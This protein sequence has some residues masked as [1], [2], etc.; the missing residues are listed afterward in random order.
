MKPEAEAPACNWLC[1]GDVVFPAMLARIEGATR[2]VRLETYIF[3]GGRLADR[4]RATLVAASRRGVQVRVLLDG[5]GSYGLS[6]GYWDDLQAAGGS[7]RTFNPLSLHRLGIRNHRKLLV[8]DDRSA[9]IGGFNIAP[10]YEGDGVTCGWCDLGLELEGPLVAQLAGSFDEMFERADMK[11]KRFVTLRRSRGPGLS[12]RAAEA[13]S[14]RL[15]LSAPGR[16]SSPIKAALRADLQHAKHVQIV[17]AYFLPTRQIR[18]QLFHVA[19]HGGRVQLILAGKSDV[20][21]SQLAGRNL[22]RRFLRAGVEIYEYQPQILHAKLMVIDDA[23]YVGSANLDQRSLQIN[24]E[25]MV[26]FQGAEFSTRAREVFADTLAHC[27]R[28]TREEW[29]AGRSLWRS[30]KQR[31]AYWLLARIDPYIA[32]RQWRALPD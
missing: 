23:V 20:K 3:K 9:F 28:V 21:V 30:L 24:Y 1:S 32:A 31:W 13:P 2:T 15:L 12:A 11:H 16:G 19:R 17:V 26:R 8:C 6:A 18:R 29:R 27:K 4:F 22:Y 7:V 14:E 25:L 10:E 5:L